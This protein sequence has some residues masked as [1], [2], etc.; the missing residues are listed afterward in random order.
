[1]DVRDVTVLRATT[2]EGPVALGVRHP[3]LV[4]PAH[5]LRELTEEELGSVLCHELAHVR[6]QDFLF[7]VIYELILLPIS[8]H[9]A[10]WFVKARVDRS[11]ELVCDELAADQ[12]STRVAY[13]R[14]LLSAATSMAGAVPSKRQGYAM[15]F[16]DKNTLEERIVSVLQG[17]YRRPATAGRMRLSAP[18]MV[19]VAVSLPLLP[20]SVRVVRASGADARLEGFAGRWESQFDGK[21]FLTLTLV[22]RGS[23]FSATVSQT[24]IHVDARGNLLHAEQQSSSDPASGL[25]VASDALLL[26]TTAKGRIGSMTGPFVTVPV[27]YEMRVTG[28]D[29]AEL[30]I[31]GAPSE[32]PPAKAWT[33]KRVAA[34]P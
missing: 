29:Q 22:D 10:A 5:L 2:T 9:P 3:A 28:K 15:A 18:S 25:R 11:R 23:A 31:R 30:Q 16:F 17:S 13:A 7:N 34:K 21:V 24:R 14:S 12:C 32:L 1:M 8:F 33:L 26:V 19:L 20:L 27:E 6:R 4:L